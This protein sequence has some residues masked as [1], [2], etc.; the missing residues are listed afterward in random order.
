MAILPDALHAVGQGLSAFIPAG[1]RTHLDLAFE[2]FHLA[3]RSP[4]S[5]PMAELGAVFALLLYGW[6]DIGR[7]AVGFAHVL[8]GK[9]SPARRFLV[10]IVAAC[11]P[12]LLIEAL[13]VAGLPAIPGNILMIASWAGI[14]TGIL[15]LVADRVGLTL[16]RLEHLG[17]ADGAAIGLGWLLVLVPGAGRTLGVMALARFLGYERQD[18]ARLAILIA[19][20]ATLVA[21]IGGVIEDGGL[22]LEPP[23]IGAVVSG[24]VALIAAFIAVSMMLAWLRRGAFTPFAGYQILA[25]GTLLVAAYRLV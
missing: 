10:L 7:L 19:T 13:I 4:L 17:A 6:Q 18:S 5:V 20:P 3:P 15:L 12:A 2:Y 11:L 23:P 16:R 8:R 9:R 21:A 24:G 14:G 22:R 1:I 25:G